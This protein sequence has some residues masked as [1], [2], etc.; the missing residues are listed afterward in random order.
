MKRFSCTGLSEEVG[1]D[2]ASAA[3]VPVPAIRRWAAAFLSWLSSPLPD[4]PG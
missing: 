1:D 4:Q 3:P 2:V